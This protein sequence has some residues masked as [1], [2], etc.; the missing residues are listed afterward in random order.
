MP[1][2]EPGTGV[3]NALPSQLTV[4]PVLSDLPLRLVHPF[5]YRPVVPAAV[6]ADGADRHADGGRASQPGLTGQVKHHQG[7]DEVFHDGAHGLDGKI[8]GLGEARALVGL[9]SRRF[10][11]LLRSIKNPSDHSDGF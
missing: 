5:G 1:D 10:F 11:S 7:G 6:V 8:A 9:A 2:D 4:H 3:G